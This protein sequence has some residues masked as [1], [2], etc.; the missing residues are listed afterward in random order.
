MGNAVSTRLTKED[1]D[2]LRS[3]EI[4]EFTVEEI[5]SLYERFQ[6]LDKTSSGVI[7]A[8]DFELIPE[9]SMNPLCHRII[10]LFDSSRLD[11]VNFRDFVR[12]LW[13]FS[14]RCPPDEKLRAAFD[15]YDV[16]GDGVIGYD[17]LMY[18]LKLL[19]GV[20]LSDEQLRIIVADTIS[21][22]DSSKKGAISLDDFKTNIGI[23]TANKL[24]TIHI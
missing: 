11:R 9:L 19:A 5:K 15:A 20:N 12:T 16:D 17:D 7:S 2:E 8:H 18:I 23:E 22:V 1:I 4:S 3:G 24:L 21:A 6:R 13:R 10:R 14:P